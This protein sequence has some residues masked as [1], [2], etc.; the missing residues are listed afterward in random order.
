MA[1]EKPCKGI[2]STTKGLGCGKFTHHRVLGLGKMCG[3]YSKFLLNTEA[4]R[5]RLHKATIKA[6]KPRLDLEQYESTEKKQNALKSLM[7]NLKTQLHSYVR[8]RDKGKPCISCQTEWNDKFQ[9]GHFYKAEL[10]SSLKFEVDNI[11]GQCFRCNNF[12]EGN[13]GGYRIGLIN[14]YGSDFVSRLDMLAGESNK[15][16]FK[17]DVDYLKEKL[18]EVK[19][20]NKQLKSKQ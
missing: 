7:V 13:E 12:L 4:G 1:K 3:C 20:L 6:K 19:E 10:F 18:K 16:D 11:S 15:Q 2:H 9:A 14:R 17:W 8:E 5:L